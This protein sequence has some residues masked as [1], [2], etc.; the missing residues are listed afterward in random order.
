MTIT[1]ANANISNAVQAYDKMLR[2][3]GASG[4]EARDGPPTGGFAEMVKD[5]A[6]GAVSTM[7]EGERQSLQAA[8]G[9]A[10]LNEVVMAVSKAEVT[11]QT[12]VSVRDKVINAYQEILRMPI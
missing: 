12:V 3:N 6:N 8:A 9:A 1:G 2:Q 5:A 4:L 7:M 10:D 11:L